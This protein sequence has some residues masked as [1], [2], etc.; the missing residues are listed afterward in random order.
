MLRPPLLIHFSATRVE[1]T[2]DVCIHIYAWGYGELELH[3]FRDAPTFFSFYKLFGICV[4]YFF[5]VLKVLRSLDFFFAIHRR[6]K[7]VSKC[8]NTAACFLPG[9]FFCY[10][11]DVYGYVHHN[12]RG[13]TSEGV[14]V[15]TPPPPLLLP[16][17]FLPPP[18][19]ILL[20]AQMLEVSLLGVRTVLRLERD[21][22]SMVK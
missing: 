2:H 3:L 6:I 15:W 16:L 7:L 17:F 5:A 12:C 9:T 1:L 22:W 18:L 21:A 11:V 14:F 19:L 4:E 8:E 13:G 10:S 20:D